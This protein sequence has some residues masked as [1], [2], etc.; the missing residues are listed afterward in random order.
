MAKWSKATY[1]TVAAVIHETGTADSP[2]V[3]IFANLFKTDNGNFDPG[4][5]REACKTAK[6]IRADI[7][8]EVMLT[9]NNVA[10]AAYVADLLES[11]NAPP[12][13]DDNA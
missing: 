7:L 5:F 11:D 4:R 2:Q 13:V 3:D 9:A 8:V 1:E 12:E 10:H 6:G